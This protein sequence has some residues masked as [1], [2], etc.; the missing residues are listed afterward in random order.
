MKCPEIIKEAYVP[1]LRTG[2][3]MLGGGIGASMLNS[4]SQNKRIKK[5]KQKKYNPLSTIGAF[6][7][8][9]LLG[10]GA[11]GYADYKRMGKW[12]KQP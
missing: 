9:S 2:I 6:M 1:G 8:G 11:G 10:A 5:G 4:S 12:I 3:G 7:G